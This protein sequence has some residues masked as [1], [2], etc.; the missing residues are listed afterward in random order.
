MSKLIYILGA[1]YSR[2][3][4]RL[5]VRGKTP[6]GYTVVVRTRPVTSSNTTDGNGLPPATDCSDAPRSIGIQGGGW[7]RYSTD[8]GGDALLFD[9]DEELHARCEEAHPVRLDV[10]YLSLRLDVRGKL[11]AA[12]LSG[13]RY[14][15]TRI[16]RDVSRDEKHLFEFIRT[17]TS[18]DVLVYHGEYVLETLKRSACEL[19]MDPERWPFAVDTSE[20]VGRCSDL[21][22]LYQYVGRPSCFESEAVSSD[23]NLAE[24]ASVMEEYR[25]KVESK[26]SVETMLNVSRLKGAFPEGCL[27]LRSDLYYR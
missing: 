16:V 1:R 24:Q 11:L 7:H 8:E 12:V 19:N 23:R 18:A 14:S 21:S 4:G 2:L 17:V 22:S 10:V 26:G 6:S 20:A 3:S 5:Q 15:R 9:Y 13:E 25:R 27:S